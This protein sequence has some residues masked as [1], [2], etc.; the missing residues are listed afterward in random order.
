MGGVPPIIYGTYEQEMAQLNQPALDVEMF[1]ERAFSSYI[2]DPFSTS[3]F[4]S[5]SAD[6]SD[7]DG[8]VVVCRPWKIMTTPMREK[9]R[10]KRIPTT[11]HVKRGE[12]KAAK[13]TSSENC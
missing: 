8:G 12:V 5:L 11:I 7:V 3:N 13:N 10:E 1:T 4:L 2:T 9:M 6:A